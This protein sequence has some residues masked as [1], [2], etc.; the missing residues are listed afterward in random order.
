MPSSKRGGEKKPEKM[1]PPE[2]AGLA[3]EFFFVGLF[4]K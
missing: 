3:R 4:N 1:T 2:K